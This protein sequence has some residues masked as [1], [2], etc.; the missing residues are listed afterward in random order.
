MVFSHGLFFIYQ[1]TLFDNE[2][3]KKTFKKRDLL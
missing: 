2:N 3:K 1:K